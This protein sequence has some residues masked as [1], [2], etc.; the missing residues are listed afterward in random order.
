MGEVLQR[1]TE[2]WVSKPLETAEML[3]ESCVMGLY[4]FLLK[5]LGLLHYGI[6]LCPRFLSS[7]H[8]V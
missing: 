6:Q 2:I 8:K 1:G 3:L 5:H 7:V 4:E